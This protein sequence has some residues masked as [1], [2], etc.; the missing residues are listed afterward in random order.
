MWSVAPAVE[1]DGGRDLRPRIRK[2]RR[3]DY[4]GATVQVIPH[5][6]DEIKRRILRVAEAADV[7]IVH[8]RDRRH[9]RRH[10]VACRSSR[11]SASCATR[12][13]A[14][15]S[16]TSTSR[17]CRYRGGRRAEDEAD[18]AL[19]Q[20]AAPHR[21]PARRPGLPLDAAAAARAARQ[22]RPVRRRRRRAVDRRAGRRPTSTRSRCVLHAQGFDDFVAATASASTR[23]ARPRRSGPSSPTASTRLE[24][25][26]SGSPSSASTS[27]CR[28]P[29]SRSSRRCARRHHHGHAIDLDFV[30]AEALSRAEVRDACS[31]TTAS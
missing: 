22:D 14:T 26:R 18:A 1:R 29:T 7:D 27:S 28:T 12:S 8:G 31:G 6:T 9:R 21:Y 10:R 23:P 16:S 2:E 17:W 11:R 5:I 4:L 24:A 19:G 30:D 3:G 13:A 15:T 25:A 20:R